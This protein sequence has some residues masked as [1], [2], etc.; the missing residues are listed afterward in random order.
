M[1]RDV[2]ADFLERF[3]DLEW[4]DA[5]LYSHCK[6]DEVT[7]G[8]VRLIEAGDG[9]A[10]PIEA[11]YLAPEVHS[12]MNVKRPVV[13]ADELDRLIL[14][15]SAPMSDLKGTHVLKYLRYGE[16]NAFAS[17][18]SKAVPVPERSTCAARH[19]WYD[20]TG[21]KPGAFFW[22]M[23]QQ[24]RHVIPANPERLICNHNLF[25][26]HPCDLSATEILA[27]Q[28]IA[29]STLVAN[30]K[31]FY[32][33]YAGTEGNLKTEVVD[34]NLLE[35]PDPRHA[36]AAVAAKLRD[37]FGRLCQR[38]TRPL[39]EEDFMECHSAERARKLAEKPSGLPLEL[40]ASGATWTWPC[41]NCSAWRAP[42]SARRSATNSTVKPPPI[43]ARYGWSRFRSRNSVPE[44]PTGNSAR[45]NSQPICGTR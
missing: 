3:G 37:A 6:R 28:A 9:T 19:R 44:P 11:A 36:T 39:V 7:S 1:P 27:L 5:P 33:R 29:N 21:A 18:K 15:V 41:S 40:Q 25:D 12:L 42:R 4:N 8:R 23:A 10:H 45:T 26:V 43:S 35:I 14:L 24:Y 13:R 20:L 38:D 34:V 16:H 32:G 2:S 22:P 31:T 30:F 17:K